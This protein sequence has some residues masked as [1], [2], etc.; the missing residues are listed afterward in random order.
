MNLA[1]V[2]AYSPQDD[3]GHKLTNWLFS[4][5]SYDIYAVNSIY[6]LIFIFG[7]YKFAKNENIKFLVQEAK[8]EILKYYTGYNIAHI[9]INNYKI[10]G[11]DYPFLPDKINCKVNF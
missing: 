1:E 10:D 9:I 2:L 6:G 11:V 5:F 8:Q 3:L 4:R 7:L